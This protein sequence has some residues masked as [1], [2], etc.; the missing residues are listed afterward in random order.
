LNGS[1]TVTVVVDTIGNVVNDP[2]L[3]TSGLLEP[4]EFDFEDDVLDAVEDA[5]ERLSKK[6]RRNDDAVSEAVRLSVR[7]YFRSHFN[8]NAVTSVHLVRV[9]G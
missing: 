8:K 2:I 9:K 4:D 7:R 1:A 3:T 6:D 5:V